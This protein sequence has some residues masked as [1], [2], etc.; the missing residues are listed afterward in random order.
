VRALGIRRRCLKDES[1]YLV[2][3][4]LPFNSAL[5]RNAEEK[6]GSAAVKPSRTRVRG[7]KKTSANDT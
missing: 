2:Y 4:D 6:D 3:L 5:N 7:T 1:M